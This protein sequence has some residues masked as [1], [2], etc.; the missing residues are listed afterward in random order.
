MRFV[1]R[2]P[3]TV[4][5]VVP[6][7]D[8]EHV[9]DEKRR[10]HRVFTPSH[11]RLLSELTTP[12]DP[13][14][15]VRALYGCL[16]HLRT[17]TL[18]EAWTV[19]VEDAWPDSNDAFC[20]V[21]SSPYAGPSSVGLRRA[22]QDVAADL[23]ATSYQLGAFTDPEMYDMGNDPQNPDPVAF[24]QTVADFD[25][26]EPIGNVLPMLRRDN[27]GTGWWGSLGRNSRTLRTVGKTHTH[28][29]LSA[30]ALSCRVELSVSRCVWATPL[31]YGA[32]R[33]G[34]TSPGVICCFEGDCR[35]RPA[36]GIC[37]P[38]AHSVALSRGP[39]LVAFTGPG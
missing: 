26:G 14:W 32:R 36:L 24:G 1:P 11:Q 30:T 34:S 4:V 18:T 13:P 21:Y 25:I 29:A 12:P 15:S 31:R 22:R 19:A 39:N 28:A 9:E 10:S 37:E 8:A 35:Q 5:R 16:E 7:T 23:Q 27:T 2:R 38:H 33:C 3:A 6:F 20:V 17:S